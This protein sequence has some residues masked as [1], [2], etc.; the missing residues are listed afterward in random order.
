MCGWTGGQGGKYHY[1]PKS[2]NE[3]QEICSP[4]IIKKIKTNKK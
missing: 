2:R 4:Y 3:I 1:A